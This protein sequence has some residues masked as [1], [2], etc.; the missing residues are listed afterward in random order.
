MHRFV[1]GTYDLQDRLTKRYP[2][3]LLENCS[4]GGGRFDPGM[5]Y[6]SPQIWTSDNTDPIE[7]LSIQFGTSLCYPASSMGAGYCGAVSPSRSQ[8]SN[9]GWQS[10]GLPWL[11]SVRKGWEEASFAQLAALSPLPCG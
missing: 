10:I 7:R 1:L 2:H 8:S 3:L 9:A 11:C 5:L 4:G 6:Y